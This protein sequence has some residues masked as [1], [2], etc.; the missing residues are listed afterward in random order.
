MFDV[1]LA[2]LV[3]VA[4]TLRGWRV[5]FVWTLLAA[6]CWPM[7]SP[8]S[9]TCRRALTGHQRALGAGGRPD[10]AAPDRGRRVEPGPLA[11]G[12]WTLEGWRMLVTPSLLAIM[13][14][15]LLVADHFHQTIDAAVFLSAATLVL[16]L[17]R[18]AL[19]FHENTALHATR[20]L[21]LTDEL[22]G[23]ANRRQFHQRL[24]EELSQTRRRDARGRDGRSRPLQ[25]AQRHARPPRR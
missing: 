20:E 8:T 6:A 4:V 21:A 19:T 16:V 25:G 24:A 7:W 2:V 10:L 15:G 17:V 11:G 12:P 13:A 3:L 9:A 22:T 1:L 23:L 14:G 5:S 18:M